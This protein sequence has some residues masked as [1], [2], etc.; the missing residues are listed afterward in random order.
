M[1]TKQQVAAAAAA[2]LVATPAVAADAFE[3]QAPGVMFFFSIPLDAKSPKQQAPALGLSFQGERAYQRVVIDTN[4]FANYERL[5]FGPLEAI[6]AKWIVAGV[7][8]AG[9]GVAVATKDKKTS[10]NMQEQQN[11]Q[12]IQQQQNQ[13][14]GGGN[15]GAVPCP[16]NC[17][18]GFRWY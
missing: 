10:Q 9:A 12:Q 2:I 7:V 4:M 5:G 11:Q 6:S 13:Q 18:F 15:N 17:S 14:N 8:A 16:T 1:F 3:G